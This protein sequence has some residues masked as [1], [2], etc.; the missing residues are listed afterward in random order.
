M[1]SNLFYSEFYV[2]RIPDTISKR[3]DIWI[4][5][6]K[7]KEIAVSQNSLVS[8]HVGNAEIARFGI[9]I[10]VFTFHARS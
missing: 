4:S 10:A 9:N 1:F 2:T 6:D 3:I 5:K 7:C 8:L